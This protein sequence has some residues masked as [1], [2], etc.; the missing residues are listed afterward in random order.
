MKQ[1]I[2]ALA[3][4]AAVPLVMTLGNSMLIP[5]IPIIERTLN[6]TPVQASLIITVYSIAAVPLIPIAGF[7]SDRFGRKVV[8]IPSL[9]LAGLG[10][11][12][13]GLASLFLSDPYRVI[14]AA[15]IMQGIGA[16]GAFPL[17]L[18]LTRDIFHDEAEVS[19]ALGVIETSNTFGKVISPILGAYLAALSWYAPF[20]AISLLAAASILAIIFWIKTPQQEQK[21]SEFQQSISQ[22]KTILLSEGR[23]LVTVYLT[24]CIIMLVLFGIQFYV[25]E[26]LEQN[27]HILG[28]RKGLVLAIPL[29]GLCTASYIAGRLLGDS[30]PL[31]KWTAFSGMAVL[32]LSSGVISFSRSLVL[33]IFILTLGF[34]GIGAALPSLDALITENIAKEQNG[35]VTSFY[36]SMRF[37]G[38]AVG[39]PI[40]AWLMRFSHQLVFWTA[41]GFSLIAV[42]LI[43]KFI[44]TDG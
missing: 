2:L 36:N 27:Y 34:S 43:G 24:G 40:F 29:A 30:K 11:L 39:P 32:A 31:L 10:G 41:A 38:V 12:I 23:W 8:I 3:A 44:K 25:S 13:A 19:H 28:T 35:T 18:P 15:R 20:A 6:L 1:K 42:I 9:M 5:V 4:L 37:V 33:L 17:T 21:V 26:Y 7:M 16:A 14:L 22:L